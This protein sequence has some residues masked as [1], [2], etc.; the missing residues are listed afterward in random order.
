MLFVFTFALVLL[1][2]CGAPA[3]LV[4]L[5]KPAVNGLKTHDIFIATTRARDEDPSVLFSGERSDDLTFARVTVSVPPSHKIGQLEKPQ[6]QSNPRQHFTIFG[7]QEYNS[8]ESFIRAIDGELR[9]IPR[10]ERNVLIFVHGYN[11]SFT[12]AVLQTAQFVEDSGFQG[13]AVLFTWA[14]RGKTFDYVYD[15]NS[16]FAARARLFRTAE[17]IGF[18]TPSV[19][20]YNLVAHSMGNI[21]TVE[22]MRNAVLARGSLNKSGKL[23]SITLASPDIDID[24]FRAQLETFPPEMRR[25]YVFV[26]DDDKALGTARLIAGGVNRVGNSDADELAELGV[27]VVDLSQLQAGDRFNHGKFSD[28]P[29]AVQLIG[30]TILAGGTLDIQ[31]QRTIGEA[32]TVTVLD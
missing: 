8:E 27:V 11:T 7:P 32:I 15:L 9:E 26:S 24:L 25:F 12:N 31:R 16:A 23:K 10:G 6:G 20:G 21:L 4:E 18:D 3:P 2:A 29:E 14:S 19:E 22:S 1:A 28:S 5:T 17:L 30:N 13:T